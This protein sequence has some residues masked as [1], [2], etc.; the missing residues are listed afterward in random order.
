MRIGYARVS[1]IAHDPEIQFRVL[2]EVR[3][4]CILTEHAPGF[5]L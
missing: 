1:T 4:E 5:T 3:C 2:E